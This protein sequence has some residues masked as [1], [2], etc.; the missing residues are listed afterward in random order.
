MSVMSKRA[1]LYRMVMPTHICPY[2]LKARD[3]LRD[4]RL[5]LHSATVDP[6]MRL[7]DAKI[8]GRAVDVTDEA[9]RARYLALGARPSAEAPPR[10][11]K[12]PPE[13]YAVATVALLG[14]LWLL[15]PVAL[16]L[17]HRG[18]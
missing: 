11:G 14:A 8:A 5:A 13:V 9:E 17:L 12:L 10:R 16:S 7:G 15:S 18:G 2:G 4:P 3:L 1:V 6:E